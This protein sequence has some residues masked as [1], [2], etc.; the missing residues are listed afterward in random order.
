MGCEYVTDQGH[1][2]SVGR[3]LT[4]EGLKKFQEEEGG[5]EA[6]TANL[7]IEENY[8]QYFQKKYRGQTYYFWLGLQSLHDAH[9]NWEKNNGGSR[10]SPQG[11]HSK[12]LFL[13]TLN[14]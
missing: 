6:I 11:L 4:E 10:L 14:D 13:E 12:K 5:W 9:G 2:C 7:N 8:D 1:M 3:C